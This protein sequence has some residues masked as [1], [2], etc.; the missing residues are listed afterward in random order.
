MLAMLVP[1]KPNDPFPYGT[2]VYLM[3]ESNLTG[4]MDS[5]LSDFSGSSYIFGPPA[6]C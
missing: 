5:V 1:V 3:K 2:V 4:V 6:R